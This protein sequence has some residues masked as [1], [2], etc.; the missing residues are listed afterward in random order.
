L[1]GL[2]KSFQDFDG[3]G[4]AGSVLAQEAKNL[5]LAHY[6][7]HVIYRYEPAKSFFNVADFNDIRHAIAHHNEPPIGGLSRKMRTPWRKMLGEEVLAL[8]SSPIAADQHSHCS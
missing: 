2:L 4:L 1:V 6:E 7:T 5:S 8:S 3:G